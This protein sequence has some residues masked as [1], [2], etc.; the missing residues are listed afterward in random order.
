MQL[1]QVKSISQAK[2]LIAEAFSDIPLGTEILRDGDLVGRVSAQTLSA[3]FDVP[4]FARSTVDGYAVK[5]G[6]IAGCSDA[7]PLVLECIGEAEMGVPNGMTVASGQCVY[8]P[9]GG[10]MPAGAD[11]VVMIEYTEP[12]DATS[13]AIYRPTAKNE[14]VLAV[15]D[16]VRS[17]QPVLR[18]GQRILPKDLGVLAACGHLAVEVYRRPRVVLISTG[19]EIVT[20]PGDLIPGKILDI[21]TYAIKG[22]LQSSGAEVVRTVHYPDDEA[23]LK[24]G[25]QE[26][27]TLADVVIVSGGSSMGP[28]DHTAKLFDEIGTPGLLMHGLAI[29]P[30]KPTIVAKAGNIPLIG[31]PG[32]PVSAMVVYR[33]LVDWLLRTQLKASGLQEAERDAV[34][35]RNVMGAPGKDTYQMVRETADGKIVPVYGKSG[36]ISLIAS[37]SGYIIIP[38]DIEGFTAG[39]HVVYHR[40]I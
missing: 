22:L 24:A 10:M 25:I 31:L 39:T 33:V 2:T 5:S 37:A 4:H 40:F 28:K 36:M 23:V 18:E 26:A 34:L 11:S 14:N 20:D 1:F 9:T 27:M 30:G 15:G 35:E 7:M 3:T 19:D 38:A 12:F 17:G 29:K 16:D 13:I 32:Q 21:N 8:V 6:E